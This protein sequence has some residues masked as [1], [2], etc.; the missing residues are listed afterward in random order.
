MCVNIGAQAP[1]IDGASCHPGTFQNQTGHRSCKRCPNG[2]YST[3]GSS[4][5][6][7][8]ATT[9][10]DNTRA[11]QVTST[12]SLAGC[13]SPCINR[14]TFG[15]PIC[16]CGSLEC[17]DNSYC[18]PTISHCSD[19]QIKCG[20]FPKF[21]R[22]G[23]KGFCARITPRGC[24]CSKCLKGYYT[25]RCIPCPEDLTLMMLAEGLVGTIGVYMFFC[26]LYYVFRPSTL[27]LTAD[28]KK[29]RGQVKNAA[30]SG[31]ALGSVL[32]KFNTIR[33]F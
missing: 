12:E 32:R 2:Q 9:C 24:K 4:S 29:L 11:A 25:S 27:A 16:T 30:K 31:G 14:R 23:T 19:Q 21:S 7:Y 28:A 5:C 6:L 3:D 13:L 22:N 33:P 1:L 8:T 18:A 20:K 10:P 26:F 15:S 17:R